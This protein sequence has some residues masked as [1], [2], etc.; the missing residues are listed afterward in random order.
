ML[1]TVSSDS[2]EGPAAPC[3]SHSE[4]EDGSELTVVGGDSQGS[5]KP[6]GDHTPAHT[7]TDTNNLPV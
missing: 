5:C 6:L 7:H 2:F 4:I 3:T 1:F